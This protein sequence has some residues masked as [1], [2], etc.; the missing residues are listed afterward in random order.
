MKAMTQERK[1]RTRAARAV[2]DAAAE[3]AWVSP[4]W[5]EVRGVE[6]ADAEAAVKVKTIK[7]ASKCRKYWIPHAR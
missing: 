6:E 2:A 3:Y 1:C 5:A 4:E 7:T